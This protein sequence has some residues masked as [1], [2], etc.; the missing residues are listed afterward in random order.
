MTT[1]ELQAL[2]AEVAEK[3]MGYVRTRSDDGAHV[4]WVWPQDGHARAFVPRFSRDIAAAFAVL[5]EWR[6]DFEL[7]RQNDIAWKCVLYRPSQEFES[8]DSTLPLAICR[9]VL[10]ATDG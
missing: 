3:V 2:D 10:K 7:R 9:A 6:G 5:S 8:W 1:D 4:L